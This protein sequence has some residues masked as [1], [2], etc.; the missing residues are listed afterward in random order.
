MVAASS[1]HPFLHWQRD[2]HPQARKR[3]SEPP[4]KR[5]KDWTSEVPQLPHPARSSQWGSHWAN[6]TGSPEYSIIFFSVLLLLFSIF[7]HKS[8]LK[9][10]QVF[11]KAERN[12]Q[13]TPLN[14]ASVFPIVGFFFLTSPPNHVSLFLPLPPSLN[15]SEASCCPP[16]YTSIFFW[17]TLE[18]L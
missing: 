8:I 12:I 11:R 14:P 5:P 16:F 10:F 2:L 6:P 15:C 7:S 17:A 1:P 4:G 3:I 9:L 13:I 18:K